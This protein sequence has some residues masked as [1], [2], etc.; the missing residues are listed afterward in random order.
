MSRSTTDQAAI[1][2]ETLKTQHGWNSRMVSVR[3]DYYSMG[4]S[5]HV[6][7]KDASIPSS[8]VKAIAKQAEVI[9]YDHY[10]GEI[11]SGGN[12]FV[13]VGYS[14]EAL[15]SLAA[16]WMGA[17]D[18]AYLE[19]AGL[20]DNQMVAIAGTPYLLGFDGAR[21]RFGLWSNTHECCCYDLAG[22]AAE[23]GVKMVNHVAAPA[24]D[25]VH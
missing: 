6:T 14:R 21:N 4:S 20:N 12:R 24:I 11:L 17:V 8:V 22:V 7:I 5:I 18:A 15:D 3:A 13:D 10:V 9:H 19:L 23:V 25:G 2:R 16:R 1:I